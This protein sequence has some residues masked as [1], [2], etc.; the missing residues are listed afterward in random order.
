MEKFFGKKMRFLCYAISS[1]CLHFITVFCFHI[2]IAFNAYKRYIQ[3]KRLLL[4]GY[5]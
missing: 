3:M 1:V 5:A 4:E 2:S